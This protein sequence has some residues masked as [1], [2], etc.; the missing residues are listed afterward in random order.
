MVNINREKFIIY[1][2]LPRLFG[3]ANDKCIP[4]SSFMI[5]GSGKFD[6]FDTKTLHSIKELGCTHIWFTGIIEHSTKTDYSKYGIIKDNPSL[7][8]GEAGSPY[9]IKDYFDVDPDLALEVENRISEFKSLIDRT[10]KQ[11][12]KVIIDFVPNHLA[13]EYFSD[14][15]PKAIKDFGVTD[16]KDYAFHPMNNFYYILDEYFKSPILSSA[17]SDD[18][19]NS[20]QEQP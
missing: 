3:N 6:D 9:A 13:R 20:L 10:H 15:K 16:K 11:G 14:S 2:V 8:K 5:N 18:I 7:V 12:L 1:Q 4:N 17:E 19:P